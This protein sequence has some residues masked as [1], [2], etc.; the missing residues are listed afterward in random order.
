MQVSK[1]GSKLKDQLPSLGFTQD[2]RR[3]LI[4]NMFVH[5]RVETAAI[6]VFEIKLVDFDVCPFVVLYKAE[7][8]HKVGMSELLQ[9][10]VLPQ[11]TGTV[12]FNQLSLPSVPGLSEEELFA[13]YELGKLATEEGLM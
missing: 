5:V 2:F 11:Q 1:C 8:L 4:I 7:V 6:T 13:K 9:Y 12:V 3:E 10:I